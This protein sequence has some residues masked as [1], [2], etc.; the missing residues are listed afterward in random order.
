MNVEVTRPVA[1]EVFSYRVA[2]VLVTTVGALLAGLLLRRLLPNVLSPWSFWGPALVVAVL[3]TTTGAAFWREAARRDEEATYATTLV[4]HAWDCGLH[5]YDLGIRIHRTY[6]VPGGFGALT[7]VP[8]GLTVDHIKKVEGHLA[9]AFSAQQC[10]V[11]PDQQRS[12]LC[13]VRV[14][15]SDPFAEPVEWLAIPGRVGVTFDGDVMWNPE[16]FPHCL[17]AGPTGSGKTSAQLALCATLG[18]SATLPGDT[19]AFFYLVDVKR[20]GWG[21]FRGGSLVKAVATTHGEALTLLEEVHAEML[22]RLALM[23]THGVDRR[24]DLPSVVRF[25][26]LYLV[27]D[28]VTSL[29]AEDLPNE[30]AKDAKQRVRSSRSILANIARLGRQAAVH[31]LLGMQ[32]PDVSLLG[33]GE[34]RD[35]VTARLALGPLSSSGRE[36]MFGPEWRTLPMSGQVGR[37]FWQGQA[38][39]PL[40]PLSVAVPMCELWRVRQAFGVC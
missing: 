30:D 13:E 4:S 31:E 7:S 6:R 35:N 19:A 22:R 3:S 40:T 5:A 21:Q 14:L 39:D 15:F 20:T 33:G 28:E 17:I 36:M 11:I 32:R 9:A 10:R 38:S 37:G 26:P 2:I 23:E 34:F 27:V 25:G 16:Q 8:R 29:L 18:L 12:D 24:Q 1:H